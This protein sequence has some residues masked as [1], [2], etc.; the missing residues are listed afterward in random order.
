MTPLRGFA[1]IGREAASL[2]LLAL[3]QSYRM[4]LS[5]LLGGSC[6][7]APSCSAYASEAVTRHGPW[8]GAWLAL[9]RILRCHPFRSG[10]YDPVPSET[11]GGP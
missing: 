9:R 4:L 1:R 5:P 2:L 3:I 8:R 10:G 7:Y 6:R 11:L